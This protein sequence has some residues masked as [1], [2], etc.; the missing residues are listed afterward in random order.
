MIKN[1]LMQSK[2]RVFNVDIARAIG[3][4]ETLVLME[5]ADAEQYFEGEEFF[6]T[7]EQISENTT[8]SE[9]QVRN[10]VRKLKELGIVETSMK[11]LPAKQHY[12]INTQA[13]LKIRPID[14]PKSG[15]SKGKEIGGAI[16]K[17]PIY[18]KPIIKVPQNKFEGKK[19]KT[20]HTKI[21]LIFAKRYLARNNQEYYFTAKDGAKIKS[22]ITKL[23]F[24]FNKKDMPKPTDEQMESA[25]NEI[26]ERAIADKWLKDNLSLS[27]I[28]SQ[29]NTIISKK[30]ND[31]IEIDQDT[32]DWLNKPY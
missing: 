22:I 29:Y 18:K 27:N 1:L 25:F 23:N 9:H 19:Q 10:S 26:L 16:Y 14:P 28:D 12:K 24:S 17:E 13:L 21:K 20:L 5:L 30:Q 3:I 31:G 6:Q 11:G 8:L 15:R 4:N 2:W 32:I 7:Y